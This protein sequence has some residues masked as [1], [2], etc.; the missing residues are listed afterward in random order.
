MG[1]KAL[2]SPPSQNG[3]LVGNAAGA[4]NFSRYSSNRNCKFFVVSSKKQGASTEEDVA[5]KEKKQSLF[6]SVTEALDFSQVRSAKDAELLDE[7]RDAT[8]SGGR[9]SR[10]QVNSESIIQY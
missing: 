1:L 8:R 9:M 5:N 3:L 4:L 2:L 6:S 10:E 7:A